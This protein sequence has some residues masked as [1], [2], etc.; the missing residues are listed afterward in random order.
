M[1]LRYYYKEGTDWIYFGF[2]YDP[3]IVEAIKE[4][5]GA[6]YNP[7]NK[8]WYIRLDGVNNY[9]VRDI[10]DRYQFENE[11]IYRPNNNLYLPEIENPLACFEVAQAIKELGL[12]REPRQYQIE[13]VTYMINHGNCINGDDCGLG[14]GQPI[15]SKVMTPDGWKEIQN[16]EIGDLV[17][18]S[19]GLAYPIKG[20][21]PK[22]EI[23]TYRFYFSDKSSFVVDIDHLHLVRTNNDRQRGKG[24][25]VLS[26]K[27]LLECGNLRYGK[28]FKSR[29]YDLPVVKPVEFSKKDLRVHPYVMGCILG[30][31][32]LRK[33]LRFFSI[34]KEIID[35]VKEL[36]PIDVSLKEDSYGNYSFKTG[37]N[38]TNYQEKHW[39][40]QYFVDLGIY[41]HKS[42]EKFIP[43]IYLYSSIEDRVE[44]LRGLMDTDGEIQKC[45]CSCFSTSS[46]R[47]KDDIV[48]LIRS[49]GGRPTVRYGE[50]SYKKDGVE[51]EC[52]GGWT[53]TFSLKTFNSFYLTRKS[54]FWNNNPRDNGLWI[55]RIE[56]EKKQKTVCISVES[57]DNSY[58][59]ENLIVTHNTG[60]MIIT[61]ELLGAFP[62]IIVT[63]A[64]VKYG[65]RVEWSKWCQREIE[66]I[67][68]TNKDINMNADVYVINY[69]ILGEKY[70]NNK[71]RL[72]FPELL[73]RHWSAAVFDEIHFLKSANSVRTRAAYK[74]VKNS[75]DIFGLSGTLAMNRPVEV[76]QPLIVIKRFNDIF[77]DV[78]K[79][80]LRYCNA[81][82]TEYGWD[83]KSSNN[84]IELNS[85]LRHF[86][87][88]RREKRDVLKELPPVA[89]SYIYCDI[90][91]KREYRKAE[92]DLID[93][94]S[95]I[96]IE[97]AQKAQNAKHLVM[98]STL[99]KL[100]IK[101]KIKAIEVFLKE[102]MESNE[103]KKILVFG[104]HREPLQDLSKRFDSLLLQ[105]GTNAKKK[106]QIKEKFMESKV[107]VLFANL[108]SAGTGMD[109]L[110]E[111]CSNIV[112]IEFPDRSTDLDQAISRLERMGQQ[113]SMN[114]YYTICKDTID[115]HLLDFINSKR[116]V[117]EAVNK[118]KEL[119]DSEAVRFLLDQYKRKK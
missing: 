24:F 38:I 78:R 16:L 54:K 26:T 25:R 105:G 23:D 113:E 68:S 50:T 30:D 75:D 85:I 87:Y 79:F 118:G 106:Q 36:L 2:N 117:T 31:G 55:D 52:H 53:I 58:V 47:L 62:A 32:S 7:E 34:D 18:S 9:L 70:T 4:I 39:F 96:D 11:H 42:T 37:W 5:K 10:I 72:R 110:Q 89:D 61:L 98:L 103:G 46:D 15:G 49:L 45:G 93:Y 109:G 59:T 43:E 56:F 97:R 119:E 8:E 83:V 77:P 74:L 20:V 104:H 6:K 116:K 107:P 94:L 35:R 88:I 111:V 66:I 63:P 84:L 101:G 22:G 13:G 40:K 51:I 82:A 86:C 48:F 92:N 90:S 28:E 108:E 12:Y 76:K 14:K 27:Q 100:S 44:L 65:W 112:F 57:P 99:R 114:V 67:D 91:N 41:N 73:D 29:N 95:E 1:A 17:I 60:Q 64:S 115:M 71:V 80:E 19:D 21:Y 33:K 102:W 3:E 81:K 69:D